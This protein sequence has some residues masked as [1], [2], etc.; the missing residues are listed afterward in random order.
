MFRASTLGHPQAYKRT[1][2]V[3]FFFRRVPFGKLD[4]CKLEEA[5]PTVRKLFV[6]SKKCFRA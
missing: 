6:W 5:K 4:D 3:L 1:E 2:R